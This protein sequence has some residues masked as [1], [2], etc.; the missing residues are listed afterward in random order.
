M[1]S[2]KRA[3]LDCSFESE[4]SSLDVLLSLTF[5]SLSVIR[6]P[7]FVGFQPGISA[8]RGSP[9]PN[10]G[11]FSPML[12]RRNFSDSLGPILEQKKHQQN[13]ECR[14]HDPESDLLK[15]FINFILT[16]F[17]KLGRDDH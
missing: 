12:V 3:N 11:R 13:V 9:Q 10:H 17:L 5:V 14:D 15:S 7:A 1:K 6:S 16:S 2:K 4:S 8:F